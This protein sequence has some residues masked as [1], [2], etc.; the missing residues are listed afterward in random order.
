MSTSSLTSIAE[1]LPAIRVRV[2]SPGRRAPIAELLLCSAESVLR[3]LPAECAG[4]CVWLPLVLARGSAAVR[5]AVLGRLRSAYGS[6]SVAPG[7]SQVRGRWWG[8]DRWFS[9]AEILT[10]L[11]V[12][13]SFDT[14]VRLSCNLLFF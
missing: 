9:E 12:R 6:N 8:L 5:D 3:S 4:D 7:F 2:S 13:L 10:A 1:V 11:R 14:S